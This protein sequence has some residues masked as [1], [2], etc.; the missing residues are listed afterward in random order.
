MKTVL[1]TYI[2]NRKYLYDIIFIHYN[3]N[4]HT[5]YIGS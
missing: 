3:D 1:L 2:V 4:N 5:C